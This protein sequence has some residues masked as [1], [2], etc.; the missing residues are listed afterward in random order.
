MD[1]GFLVT[2][3]QKCN[4][5][6]EFDLIILFLHVIFASRHFIWANS[7]D[8]ILRNRIRLFILHEMPKPVF[9]EKIRKIRKIF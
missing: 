2:R 1:N 3:M 8:N 6:R 9:V 5:I 7:A 4:Y